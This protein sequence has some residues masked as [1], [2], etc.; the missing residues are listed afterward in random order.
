MQFILNIYKIYEINLFI[1]LLICVL[2]VTIEIVIT[3]CIYEQIPFLNFYY[4]LNITINYYFAYYSIIRQNFTESSRSA[5]V[6]LFKCNP[7]SNFPAGLLVFFF[8]LHRVE[9]NKNV[10]FLAR[11]RKMWNA[12]ALEL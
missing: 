4:N 8:A 5:S 10:L 3:F 6:P 7:G 2:F 9:I 1:F 12:A 11:A